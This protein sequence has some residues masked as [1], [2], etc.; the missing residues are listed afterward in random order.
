MKD[1]L[2]Y[3]IDHSI[4]QIFPI[5]RQHRLLL[6]LQ[7]TVLRNPM[8]SEMDLKDQSLRRD[9]INWIRVEG[10]TFW[11]IQTSYLYIS[12]IVVSLPVVS[13]FKVKCATVA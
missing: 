12:E 7:L 1:L 4:A 11:V 13:V 6:L 5:T 2:T 8:S 10:T 3:E 9:W